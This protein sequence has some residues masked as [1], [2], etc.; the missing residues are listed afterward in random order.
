MKHKYLGLED[1]AY[2]GREDVNKMLHLV[3]DS[4]LCSAA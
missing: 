3:H 4:D 2:T 1:D